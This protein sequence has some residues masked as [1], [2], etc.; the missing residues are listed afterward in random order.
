MGFVFSYQDR[1][2]YYLLDW[3]KVTASFS[4]FGVQPRGMR[5][6]VV[7][8]PGGQDPTGA[9]FWSA[10]NVTNSTTLRTNDLAWVDGADYDLVLRLRPGLIELEMY[11]GSTNLVSWSVTNNAYASGRFGYYVSSLQDVRFGQIVLESL[12]PLITSLQRTNGTN[13]ALTWIN[14]LPPFQVQN[15]TNLALGGWLDAGGLTT[16]QSQTVTSPADASF[17]RVR[18]AIVPP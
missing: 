10:L 12:A 2:H 8:V 13:V 16:N 3:K 1:G 15:R 4:S 9:D 7:H 17:F 5:L 18:G 11:Q 6:R 14:G